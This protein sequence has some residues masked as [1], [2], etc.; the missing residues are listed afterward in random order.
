M[1][2]H[3]MEGFRIG[4][5][6]AVDRLLDVADREDRARLL[7]R[8]GAGE[9]FLG[10][11]RDD[12]PLL[13]AGVLRLVDQDVVEAAVELEQHP[14]RSARAMQQVAR[15]EDQIVVIERGMA[16]LVALV[17]GQQRLAD[18]ERGDAQRSDPH[19]LEFLTQLDQ[20]VGFGGKHLGAV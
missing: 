12:L 3:A 5:L 9:E 16:R 11:C 6:E 1:H 17:G 4:A 15:A 18:D 19:G 14:G 10:Q 8:A 13:R 20:P 7:A 2:A